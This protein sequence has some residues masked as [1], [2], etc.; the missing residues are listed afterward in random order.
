FSLALIYHTLIEIL[1]YL[2]AA[3]S[4]A[5]LSKAAA[6][7]LLRNPEILVRDGLK[8]LA[9]SVALVLVGAILEVNV[10]YGLG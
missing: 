4:G 8:Y 1:V 6:K 2:I 5:I 9:L 7:V 10:L 3:I